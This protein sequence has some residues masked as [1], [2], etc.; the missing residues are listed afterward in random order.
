MEWRDGVERWSGGQRGENEAETE[1]EKKGKIQTR[2]AK[3]RDGGKE[4]EEGKM[5]RE[6]K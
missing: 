2:N 5:Q 3:G 1:G 4:T 6:E